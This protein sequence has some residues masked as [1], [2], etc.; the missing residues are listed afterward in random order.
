[1]ETTMVHRDYIG[2]MEKKMSISLPNATPSGVK[3]T[4]GNTQDDIPNSLN[5]PWEG[6]RC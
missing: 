2:I 6:S 3:A 4:S 5:P 1:M